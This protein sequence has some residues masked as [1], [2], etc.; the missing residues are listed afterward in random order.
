[1][2]HHKVTAWYLIKI[3]A[4]AQSVPCTIPWKIRAWRCL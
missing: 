1:M 3:M 2:I 4:S